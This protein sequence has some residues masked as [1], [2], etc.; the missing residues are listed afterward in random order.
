[1][2]ICLASSSPRRR[3]LLEQANIVF[4]V[5]LPEVDESLLPSES[6]EQYVLRLSAAK[7][8]S[9]YEER[10][11]RGME[12]LPV[13]AADT[14]VVL[15][16]E[17]LGKPV[18]KQHARQMLGKLSDRT[19]FVF[20]AITLVTSKRESSR[21]SESEVTFCRLTDLEISEYVDSGEPLDKAGAY[22][23]QGLAAAFVSN[24][25]GSYTGVVGLPLFELN[26]MLKEMDADL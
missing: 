1:M 25:A 2:K 16:G 4:E 22:G 14:A 12:P 8:R 6:A 11:S 15:A 7:A 3:Q 17:I 23:I 21:V 24:I 19:H 10:L 18:D 20:S 5:T 26:Q 13:L 9:A